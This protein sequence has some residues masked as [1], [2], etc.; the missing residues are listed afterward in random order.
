MDL[1]LKNRKIDY[2]I[3]IY[4]M[5]KKSIYINSRYDNPFKNNN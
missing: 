5:L 4:D 1:E 3:E 2:D